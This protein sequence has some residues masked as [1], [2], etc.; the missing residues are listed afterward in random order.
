M[1]EV[2]RS[3]RQ[4][5][6]TILARPA[7]VV[8]TVA[9]SLE[10]YVIQIVGPGGADHGAAPSR[11]SRCTR[12]AEQVVGQ[13]GRHRP[14][15]D[16]DRRRQASD[17]HVRR[18][19]R[20]VPGRALLEEN[21]RVLDD[22]K[23]RTV[24]VVVLVTAAAALARVADRPHGDRPA[25]APDA[26]RHGRRA[27]GAARRR[28]AGLRQGRGRSARHGVQRDAR[29]A[30]QLA[31]SPATP[32]R[33]RRPR[34]PHAVD[35]R[36]NEPGRAAPPSRSRSRDAAARA[37]GSGDRDRGA[38]RVG[39]GD[40]RRS[41]GERS[42][43]RPATSFELGEVARTVAARAQRRH[44]RQVNVTAD[45]SV[46]EASAP[47]VERAISNLVDNAAK[48]D[49]SGG[50]IDV[51]VADRSVVVHDRGPGIAAEDRERVFDRFYRAEGARS[52]PGSGLGLSIVREVAE[53]N[54]GTVLVAERPGG[55][56]SVGFTTVWRRTAGGAQRARCARVL[57]VTSYVVGLDG[58]EHAK[59]ALEWARGRG[60]A[61]TRRS[62]SPTRGRSRSS[63]ATKRSP[64]S[65]PSTSSGSPASSSTR[66]SSSSGDPRITGRLVTG[67]PGRSLVD[68]AEEVG[69]PVTI[70]VGHGGSSKASLLFGS[71]AHYVIHHT[72]RPV[73]V[74]RG[75][76]RLPVRRVVVGVDEGRRHE[77]DAPSLAALRWAFTLPGVEE[78]QVA[79]ADFVPGVAAGPVREPGVESDEET[80][81][82]D[83]ALRATDQPGH[84]RL[85]C[86]AERCDD[87]AGRR[88]GHWCLRP[89]RGLARGRPGRHRHARPP[90]ACRADH[91]VD[92]S[93]GH[94]ARHC[95]VAVVH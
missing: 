70:V 17:V 4:A 64:R 66:R 49:R 39:R 79:H 1:E 29:R 58:S 56:V 43:R 92:G 23:W 31:R 85:G 89:H 59:A 67:H 77:P 10:V 9:A 50:P 6:V 12:E 78:V 32:R 35:Q 30:G 51:V 53:R 24:L 5:M 83:A 68:L 63:R 47:A 61:P 95:P 52:L 3:I 57:P 2:D 60:R 69:Q 75:N 72:R 54:G 65:T 74:V 87:R 15:D 91:R 46:V 90:R 33:G 37:G 42:T 86:G 38:R 84:G 62:S 88:R 21:E 40:R 27:V 71:T 28:G 7:I 80:T 11:R 36:A 76:A 44:G 48:F 45:H 14:R 22:L 94:R 73:V 81:E 18:P 8:S 26:G 41:P 34:A 16:Q 93:R 19:R 13:P 25:E 82:D 55:G 20:R